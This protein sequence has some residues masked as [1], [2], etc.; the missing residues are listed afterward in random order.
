M[1]WPWSRSRPVD[2]LNALR[3][4]IEQHR[5]EI[6]QDRREINETKPLVEEAIRRTNDRYI[7]VEEARRRTLIECALI[8]DLTEGWKG[9]G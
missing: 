8:R 6:E 3:R 9:H 7:A 1:R 4:E 2:R 5:R